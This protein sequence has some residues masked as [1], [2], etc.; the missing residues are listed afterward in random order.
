ALHQHLINTLLT[1]ISSY[2]S[3]KGESK[4]DEGL[5]LLHYIHE[6]IYDPEK[7]IASSIA[8]HFNISKTYVSEYFKKHTGASMQRYILEYKIALAE[9]RLKHSDMKVNEIA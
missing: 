9:I 5:P 7:I 2:D 1:I 6:N 3:G 8:D 4:S